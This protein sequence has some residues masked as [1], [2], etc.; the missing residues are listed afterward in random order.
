M[1]DIL[2]A[3][4]LPLAPLV[5]EAVLP[6]LTLRRARADLRAIAA[7]FTGRDRLHQSR[8]REREGRRR[9]HGRA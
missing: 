4:S 9:S 7:N 3:H 6:G 2:K 8:L 1:A 5:T